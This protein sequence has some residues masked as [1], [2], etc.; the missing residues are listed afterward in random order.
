MLLSVV[1]GFCN[2]AS[3]RCLHDLGFGSRVV[4]HRGLCT[5]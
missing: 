3:G 2:R 5:H 4:Q 1:A